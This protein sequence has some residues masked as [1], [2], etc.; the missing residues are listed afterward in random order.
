MSN[1]YYLPQ[2]ETDVALFS[3][4]IAG[5]AVT[6]GIYLNYSQAAVIW[7]ICGTENKMISVERILQYSNIASEAP[8]VIENSRP[9]STWPETGTISFE[10][11]QV[12]TVSHSLDRT[13]LSYEV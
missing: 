6:Y 9:S 10:N 8:L 1:A 11:L 13:R 3:T 4:G 7:N 12:M 5:L 2:E